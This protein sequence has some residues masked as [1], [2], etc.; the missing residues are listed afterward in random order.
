MASCLVIKND[1]I[2]DLVLAS[3]LIASL[4][5]RFG[6]EVDLV[7]C[8]ENREIAE[9]IEPLRERLYVSRDAMHFSARAWSGGLL[10]PRVPSNDAAVL[11]RIRSRRYDVAICL[12]RFIRQ[13]SLVIMQSVTADRKLCAWQLP[14]NASGELAH[15]ASRGWQHYQGPPQVTSELLYATEFLEAT[16]GDIVD[17]RPRLSFCHRQQAAPG[18][19]RIALGIGGSSMRWPSGSWYELATALGESGWRLSL[20]G[21]AEVADLATRIQRDVPGTDNRVGRTTLREMSELLQSCDAY[22]GND[23]GIAHLASLVARKCLIL[24]GGGTFRRFFPWP[25][26]QGQTVVFHALDCFDCEWICKFPE[27]YC[28]TFLRV[29]DVH[30]A[31]ERMMADTGDAPVEIDANPRE[32][33]Y[34]LAWRH[35]L[36]IQMPFALS[37]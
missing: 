36:G 24:S 11:R 31:F 25:T 13:N 9:G 16:L 2:G 15:R 37:P 12:R 30:A 20:F 17:P 34:D 18:T 7:T 10:W 23:T 4:G 35:G 32:A 22:V 29:R 27:R 21:G 1:G 28:L 5:Q 3:G 8:E 26:R 33:S 14:T 6:G 19:R